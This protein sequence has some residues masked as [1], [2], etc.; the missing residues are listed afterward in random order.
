MIGLSEAQQA[1]LSRARVLPEE[2]VPLQEAAGRFLARDF[3]AKSDSP[4]FDNSAVDGFAVRA[5]DT[6]GA[7]PEAGRSLEILGTIA[8]GKPWAGVL[9]RGCALRIMTGAPIP[10]GSDAVAMLEDSRIEGTQAVLAR[11]SPAGANVRRRG[12][13]FREGDLLLQAGT[14]VTAPVVALLASQGV[15]RV[16]I[17]RPPRVALITTGSEVVSPGA[18]LG[19]GQIY[20]ANHEGLLAALRA[21]AIHPILSQ[22]CADDMDLLRRQGR[23]AFQQ[24]EVVITTGG[25]SVGDYD[26]V[27]DIASFAGLERV[28]WRVAMKPGK[29]ILFGVYHRPEG[30]DGLFFGLAGNPVAALLSFQQFLRPALERMMGARQEPRPKRQARVTAALEKRAGRQELVRGLLRWT[31]R[32]L[33]V[34]P[35]H[36]RESHMLLGLAR[37]DCVIHL[38]P[39]AER[40]EAGAAVEVEVLRW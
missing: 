10:D 1:I 19:P 27:R 8:A 13:E 20:N 6:E 14:P 38:P 24:A 31:D 26:Y 18:E 11:R 9:S 34:D 25:V 21:M 29:A 32:E 40:V 30:R 4:R 2:T 16:P 12:E 17:R 23:E 39:H 36:A 3:V 35:I 15:S 37:A 5:A 33:E 7:G 28:F 22:H